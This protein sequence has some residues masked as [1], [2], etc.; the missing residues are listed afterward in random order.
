[1]VRKLFLLTPLVLLGTFGITQ[2]AFGAPMPSESLKVGTV[3]DMGKELTARNSMY[4]PRSFGGKNYVVQINAP[5]RAVGCYPAGSARY[6]ALANI[7]DGAEVRMA[8]AFPAADYVLLAGGASN[9]YFSRIDPNLE[10]CHSGLHD[11]SG[12]HAQFL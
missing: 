6:E 11:E 3:I 5:Q 12:R 7:K 1:M 4:N 10:P 9:D 8:G 2:Q